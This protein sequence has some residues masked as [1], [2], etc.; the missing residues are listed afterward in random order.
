MKSSG[1]TLIELIVV[2]SIIALLMA[3]SLPVSHRVREGAMATTCQANIR[4]LL[5]EF[6]H[7][8]AAHERLPYGFAAGKPPPADGWLG[9]LAFNMPGWYWP[10]FIAAVNYKSLRDRRI[11]ECP[12]KHL[13]DP[14]LQRDVLCGNYGVNRSLCRSERDVWQYRE[15]FEGLPLSTSTVRHP[16]SSLL[17]VDSGYALIC[18]W[19]A[20]DDPLMEVAGPGITDTAY[21]PGLAINKDRVLWSEQFDDAISGRHPDKTVNVGF[22]DGHIERKKADDLLV[23]K[24]DEGKYRNRSP[25]WEPE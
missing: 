18:W 5:L 2:I 14:W 24:I 10:N 20:R 6:Q 16:G 25:L 22:L 21:V 9:S 3:L 1:F 15:A 4:Q 19:Q 8:E 23:E 11:L 17:L 13:D 12:A 7:Y